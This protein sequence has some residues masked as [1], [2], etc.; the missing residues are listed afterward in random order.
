M[1][2]RSVNYRGLDTTD[3]RGPRCPTSIPMRLAVLN[4]PVSTAR[5]RS[6]YLYR[7]WRLEADGSVVGHASTRRSETGPNASVRHAGPPSLLR[8]AVSGPGWRSSVAR[9]ATAFRRPRSRPFPCSLAC[10]QRL[11]SMVLSRAIAPTWG[12]AGSGSV[13][14]SMARGT[15]RSPESRRPIRCIAWPMRRW[16]AP[17]PMGWNWITCVGRYAA[18]ALPTLSRSRRLRTSGAQQRQGAPLSPESAAWA[19]IAESARTRGRLVTV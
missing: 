15:A 10:G 3:V 6:L 9:S 11:T 13:R 8:G 16:S 12:H 2:P 4:E 5:P 7:R 19:T 1:S 18:V 17:S 14:R